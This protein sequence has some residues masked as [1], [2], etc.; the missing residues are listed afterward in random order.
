MFE[1]YFSDDKKGKINKIEVSIII[2]CA[3]ILILLIKYKPSN[4]VPVKATIN[5]ITSHQ[6][7]DALT[8]NVYVDYIY[9]NTPYT[10]IYHSEYIPGWKRGTE[11]TVYINPDVPTDIYSNHILRTIVFSIGGLSFIYLQKKKKSLQKEN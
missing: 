10:H 2:V 11:L 4:Y 8:H 9:D 5:E 7:L 3:I 6:S 1:K